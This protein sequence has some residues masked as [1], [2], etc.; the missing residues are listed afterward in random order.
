MFQSHVGGLLQFL[1]T[2]IMGLA[3][4]DETTIQ[5]PPMIAVDCGEILWKHRLKSHPREHLCVSRSCCEK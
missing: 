2:G 4:H 5:S 3:V 1:R